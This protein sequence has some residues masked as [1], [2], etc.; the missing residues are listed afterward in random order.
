MVKA[1]A[2]EGLSGSRSGK[3]FSLAEWGGVVEKEVLSCACHDQSE[4][5]TIHPGWQPNQHR[6]LFSPMELVLGSD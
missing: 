2:S 3:G 1:G 4:A 6:L 5:S